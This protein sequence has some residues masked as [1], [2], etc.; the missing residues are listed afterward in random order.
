MERMT[1]KLDKYFK[2]FDE[3]N[4][5][6]EYYE[7]MEEGQQYRV[8]YMASDLATK[9]Y[10]FKEFYDEFWSKGYTKHIETASLD[11]EQKPVEEFF[12]DIGVES[13]LS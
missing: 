10:S 8:E 3:M 1:E 6:I 7:D 9:V 5:V 2:T 13:Y 11:E 12:K 4:L